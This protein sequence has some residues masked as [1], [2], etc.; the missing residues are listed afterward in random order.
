[1]LLE[2]ITVCRYDPIR[3]AVEIDADRVLR[4]RQLE[5]SNN[6]AN[7]LPQV[8]ER[9]IELELARLD[10]RNVKQLVYQTPQ[11]AGLRIEQLE[12]IDMRQLLGLPLLV[13][14]STFVEPPPHAPQQH[15]RQPRDG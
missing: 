2:V 9:P 14:W 7:Q 11:P 12:A 4:R 10:S 8:N 13:V 3:R 15:L 6:V 5:S 1:D